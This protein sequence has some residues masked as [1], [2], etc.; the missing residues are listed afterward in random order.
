MIAAIIGTFIWELT[1]IDI[2]VRNFV[3]YIY[4]LYNYPNGGHILGIY[5]FAMDWVCIARPSPLYNQLIFSVIFEVLKFI[6]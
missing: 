5:D 6:T 1:I 2:V 3:D 4:P